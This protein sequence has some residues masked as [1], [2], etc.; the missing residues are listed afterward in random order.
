MLLLLL[1]NIK[2]SENWIALG[3]RTVP[4]PFSVLHGDWIVIS[5][6]L[7]R[8][9]RLVSVHYFETNSAHLLVDLIYSL[10]ILSVYKM[11]IYSGFATRELEHSYNSYVCRLL[12]LLQT[13]AL[14]L[15]RTSGPDAW[16]LQFCKL[17]RRLQQLETKKYLQPKFSEYCHKLT[18][19]LASCGVVSACSR[20]PT[21][22]R[23]QAR[24]C[25]RTQTPAVPRP[26]SR[27]P[28][29][30]TASFA[31]E[32][33]AMPM[34]ALHLNRSANI[35]IAIDELTRGFQIAVQQF[36]FAQFIIALD[37]Q[38]PLHEIVRRT[39]EFLLCVEDGE[40]FAKFPTCVF[41]V[42]PSQNHAGFF[43]VGL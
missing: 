22:P 15:L 25:S 41:Q 30:R 18:T 32:E 26:L 5:C 34:F 39:G 17:H 19:E 33:S 40:G 3:G 16:G 14:Q 24:L 6:Y 7:F 23:K 21:A 20:P 42:G 27:E 29:R 2:S 43:D 37:A 35:A 11:S 13:L 38:N 8:Q 9:I 36:D 4:E 12:D 28:Q 31:E 10:I 1:G